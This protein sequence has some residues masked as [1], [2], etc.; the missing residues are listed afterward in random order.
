MTTYQNEVAPSVPAQSG[1]A[2]QEGNRTA[3]FMVMLSLGGRIV[4]E[5]F[6]SVEQTVVAKIQATS[7]V[8]F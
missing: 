4:V 6:K 5:F 2:C 3:I 7:F 1:S 8:S